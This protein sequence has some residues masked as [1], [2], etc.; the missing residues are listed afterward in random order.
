MVPK[1]SELLPE[2]DTPVKTVS[3]RFGSSTLRSLR[4][5]SRAPCTRITSWVSAAGSA[6]ALVALVALIVLIL[7]QCLDE[8]AAV[9]HQSAVGDLVRLAPR[10]QPDRPQHQE[11]VSGAAPRVPVGLP[12]VRLPQRLVSHDVE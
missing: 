1:T 4:L 10:L 9:A 3:R 6:V 12:D 7:L 11:Q 2:P 8:P 5:F